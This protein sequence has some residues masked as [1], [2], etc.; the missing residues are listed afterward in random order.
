MR[1]TAKKVALNRETL[2]NLDGQDFAR[3]EGGLAPPT[4]PCYPPTYGPSC[5]A[6]CPTEP[7]SRTNCG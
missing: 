2:R 4:Y 1:K 3:V 5:Y 7:F 6:A